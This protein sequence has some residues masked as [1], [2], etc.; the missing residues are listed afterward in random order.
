MH[1]DTPPEG[2]AEARAIA[3]TNLFV[4]A[5]LH[6]DGVT[7]SVTVRDLSTA[8]AQIE[9]TLCPEIGSE[10]ILS[11]GPLTVH[12]H[13][14]WRANRRCGLHFTSPVVVQ[15]WMANPVNRQQQRVD[16]VVAAVKAGA[17][18]FEA[19]AELRA[20]TPA[21]AAEDLEGVSRLLEILGDALAKDP[22]VVA[23]H[24]AQLQNL[25]IALQTLTALAGTM[26]ADDPKFE[27]SI[28]R[29]AELRITCAEVLRAKP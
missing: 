12:C 27:A 11:R 16:H 14:T 3:R 9:S 8:G 6:I 13:V 25:D 1:E 24:A 4:G 20:A 26:E 29:L 5:T 21:Q 2:N 19:P 10:A 15:E 28:A 17:V 22:A 18:P 23:K 7:H